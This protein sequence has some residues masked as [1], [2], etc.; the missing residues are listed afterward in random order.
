MKFDLTLFKNPWILGGAVLVGG[1]VLL[2][3]R[4]GGSSGVSS[5]DVLSAQTA[6][7]AAALNYAA[8]SSTNGV[9]VTQAELTSETKSHLDML[10]FVQNIFANN[11]QVAIN[12]ANVNAGIENNRIS[13]QGALVADLA[14]ENTRLQSAYLSAETSKYGF[15]TQTKVAQIS[16]DGTYATATGVASIQAGTNTFDALANTVGKLFGAK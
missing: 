4:G 2:G 12:A 10:S 1:L 14:A 3:S 8:I 16:A 5:S 7:N 6:Q 13:T 15:D 11:S 9:S